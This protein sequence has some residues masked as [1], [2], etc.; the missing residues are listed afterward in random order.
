MPTKN[1]SLHFSQ[2]CLTSSY[3]GPGWLSPST[4]R[5]WSIS[6]A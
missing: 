1:S 2:T 3:S 6:D 4:A 5:S